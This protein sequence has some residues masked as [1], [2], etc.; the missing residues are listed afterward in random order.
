MQTDH[1]I[2]SCE[3]DYTAAQAEVKKAVKVGSGLIYGFT[4][5]NSTAATAFLMVYDAL[6]ASVTVGTTVPSFVFP[7]S[8]SANQYLSLTKPIRMKTGIVIAS[9]TAINNTTGAAQAVSLFYA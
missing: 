2:G 8:A 1:D 4:V 7:I 5:T 3:Y 6:A 9:C